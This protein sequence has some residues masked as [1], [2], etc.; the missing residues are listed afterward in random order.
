[1]KKY[2][3]S[4]LIFIFFLT[5]CKQNDGAV[6]ENNPL[7]DIGTEQNTTI[8]SRNLQK[9]RMNTQDRDR[10]YNAPDQISENIQHRYHV[11]ER[12]ADRVAALDGVKSA[13]V[14]TM[15]ANAYVA[16]VL[17]DEI[18]K[19]KREQ[20]EAKIEKAVKSTDEHIK[21]VYISANPDFVERLQDYVDDVNNRR[22]VKGFGEE[23]SELIERIFPSRP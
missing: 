13:Y 18:E 8:D 10:Y 19:G 1:M 9:V 15:D 20:L 21:N 6:N 7:L 16:V 23:L 12:A 14:I 4:F 11:A 5:G 22:P 2:F 3:Y 17:K